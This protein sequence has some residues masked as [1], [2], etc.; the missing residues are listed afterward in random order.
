MLSDLAAQAWLALIH[1]PGL[2]SRR[3]L[4]LWELLPD[5]QGILAA[6][7]S[8]W[9]EAGLNAESIA[10]LRQP[11]QAR[12]DNTL[13]W[14]AEAQRALVAY[15][16]VRYPD[17][18][19]VMTDPPLALFVM[20]NTELLHHP[21]L[22]IVGTRHPTPGGAQNARA[23][24]RDLAGRGVCI[25]SGLA[26]GIDAEA[27]QGALEAQGYTLAVV[28]TGID[29]VYPAQHRELAHAIV[30]Q[31]GL[32]VSELPLGTPPQPSHFPRRNR[33]MAA[34]SLG[35][36]VVEAAPQSGSLITARLASEL[37]REVFA[38]PGSI[39]N[40]MA[41]GCHQLIRQGAKLVESSADILEELAAQLQTHRVRADIAPVESLSPALPNLPEDHARLL[42]AMGFDPVSVDTLVERSGLTAAEVSSILL[43]TQLQGHISPLAGGL[44]ARSSPPTTQD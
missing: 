39:H 26:Q 12:I 14:L 41:R 4:R 21:S 36:L 7:A 37:G 3:F 18:L 44:Y 32:I 11:D 19:R 40:P 38:I 8:L 23:F 33:I 34:L 13:A 43:I 28:G 27:H 15:D 17:T 22:A 31:A 1:A 42:D 10:A 20:G 16:D 25:A 9:R 30:N 2:G 29:R 5:A 6:P 24:A 35:T